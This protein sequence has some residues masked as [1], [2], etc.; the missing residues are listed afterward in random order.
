[1]SQ[2]QG[3]AARLRALAQD[4]SPVSNDIATSARQLKALSAEVE[5]LTRSGVSTGPLQAALQQALARAQ[6]AADAA[7]QVKTEGVGWAD[8][9]ARGGGGDGCPQDSQSKLGDW[10]RQRLGRSGAATPEVALADLP[11]L[12]ASVISLVCRMEETLV[13]WDENDRAH[14][15]RW[16]GDDSEGVRLALATRVS[17]IRAAVDHVRL[18]PFEPGEGD[19]STFAY[20]YPDS[21]ERLIYVDRLFWESGDTP[22]DSQAGIV[23]HELSHF[24]DIGGTGD[25]AYGPDACAELAAN[26]PTAALANADNFEYFTEGLS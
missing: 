22:P 16:F 21:S 10:M 6:T 25:Y 17:R 1:M 19:D 3:I 9:L 23:F 18:V 11:E 13:R 24:N 7:S 15:R 12:Q 4:A 20:V 26:Y 5:S 2:L 8:H 14:A